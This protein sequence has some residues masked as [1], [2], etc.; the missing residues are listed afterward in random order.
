MANGRSPHWHPHSAA[1]LAGVF[2]GA[3]RRASVITHDSRDMVGFLWGLLVRTSGMVT[4]LPYRLVPGRGCD[5]PLKSHF[6]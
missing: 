2:A 1:V 4:V 5:G 3:H 6:F